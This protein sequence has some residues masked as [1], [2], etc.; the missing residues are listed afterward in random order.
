MKKIIKVKKA[1]QSNDDHA[2]AELWAQFFPEEEQLVNENWQ[3]EVFGQSAKLDDDME[4]FYEKN[5][6]LLSSN[7]DENL[8]ELV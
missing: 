2:K 3:E 6:N 5:K 8:G 7:G 1:E 4:L